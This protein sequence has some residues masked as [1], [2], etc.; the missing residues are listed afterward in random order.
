MNS[1][2]RLAYGY[3]FTSNGN[4]LTFSAPRAS[5]RSRKHRSANANSRMASNRDNATSIVMNTTS[6]CLAPCC[7]D[8]PRTEAS[9][10]DSASQVNPRNQA[11]II[12]E[13]LHDIECRKDGG[14]GDEKAVSGRVRGRR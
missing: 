2:S 9:T 7:I 13:Y 3:H 5:S 8:I 12:R 14:T 1:W 6:L 4:G 11:N 10:V